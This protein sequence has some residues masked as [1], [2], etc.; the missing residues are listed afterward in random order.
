[1][2]FFSHVDYHERNGEQLIILIPQNLH[3]RRSGR[4]VDS[5]VNIILQT[6]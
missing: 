5:R 4:V 2:S 6:Q 3:S 1:M